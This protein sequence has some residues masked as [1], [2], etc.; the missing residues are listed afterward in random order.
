MFTRILTATAAGLLLA[1]LAVQPTRAA[2]A[3]ATSDHVDLLTFNAPIALPGVVLAAGTYRFEV[4][5][6]GM[7]TG[8]VRVASRDGRK[9]YLTQYARIVQKPRE[10]EAAHVTFGEVVPGAASRI[11]TWFPSGEDSGRQFIYN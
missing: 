8:L 11:N 7:P 5:G 1:T 3:W 6:A 2:G 10:V 9:I 4:P